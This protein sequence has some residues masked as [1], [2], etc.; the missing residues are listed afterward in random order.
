[1]RGPWDMHRSGPAPERGHGLC[2]PRTPGEAGRRQAR[3]DAGKRASPANALR[4][5]TSRRSGSSSLASGRS[6][7]GPVSRRW[8]G[9][10]QGPPGLQR[11][12][13]R[14]VLAATGLGG[15]GPRPPR[16]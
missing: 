16:G 6:L 8:P 13:Q 15:S 5:F 4:I 14:A 2:F 9:F 11:S 12:S 7:K 3:E 1:M 10:A